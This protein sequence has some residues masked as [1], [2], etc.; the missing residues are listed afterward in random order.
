MIS[1]IGGQ[2]A[3]IARTQGELNALKA[4]QDKY[5]PLPADATEEREHIWP[6]CVTRQIQRA[7][8]IRHR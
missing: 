2:V 4:A 1:D 3:D 6:N 7:G 8:K 5:G